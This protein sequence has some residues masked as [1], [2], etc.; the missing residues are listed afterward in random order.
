MKEA[1]KQIIALLKIKGNLKAAERQKLATLQETYLALIKT[2]N[3][4]LKNELIN[5]YQNLKIEE[6]K[7]INPQPKDEEED[8]SSDYL[9]ENMISDD[10]SSSIYPSKKKEKNDFDSEEHANVDDL[11]NSNN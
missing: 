5:N 9:S 7:G 2:R 1:L 10:S 3:S 11:A 8:N 6:M 4:L